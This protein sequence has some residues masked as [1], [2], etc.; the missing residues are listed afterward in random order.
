M[1][2][3]VLIKD[4][5]ALERLAAADT[6]LF[7]KTGTLTLGR[8]VPSGPLPLSGPEK[9]AALALAQASRH[10]LARALAAALASEGIVAAQAESLTESPGEGLT[11]IVDGQ[12]ARLGKPAW[13]GAAASGDTLH[14]AFRLGDAPPRLLA[15]EDGLRPDATATLV[16]LAALGLPAS[17]IS[18]DR[19]EAVAGVASKLGIIGQSELQPADK[20]ALINRL[21]SEGRHV[22]MVGDG[23]NDGPAL[24]AAHV[25]MA[26][27]SAS[28]VG[29]TA[30]DLVFLGDRLMPVAQ[31]IVAARRTM[32]IVRQNFAMAIGYNVLAV[33]LAVAGHVT[34]LVAALAMSGSSLIVVANALRLRRAARIDTE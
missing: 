32:A 10:P 4:G 30:A 12:Q 31:A 23:L 1:R 21:Q 33:P 25:S 8:P 11:A 16:Q 3:G 22:L 18:G 6:V 34:P 27:A 26:P 7:D 17:I 19:P 2:A 5:A 29:K 9:S 14:T 15:F 13:L 20:L 24:N 28:D